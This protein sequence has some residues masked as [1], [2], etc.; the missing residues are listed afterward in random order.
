ML[1]GDDNALHIGAFVESQLICVASV[2]I[3]NR[4]ARLRKFATLPEFQSQGIGGKVISHILQYLLE[5]SVNEFW[6]DA[7]EDA[8]SFYERFGLEI[9]GERFY[10]E[11]VTYF[12]MVKRLPLNE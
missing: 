10:K 11:D 4:S 1:D 2:F 3:S 7:R 9:E 6:C 8:V 5:Q 12:K